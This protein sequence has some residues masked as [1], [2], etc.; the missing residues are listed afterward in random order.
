MMTAL[1]LPLLVW[2]VLVAVDAWRTRRDVDRLGM[3]VARGYVGE[4]V[5][6][7]AR[8]GW[9]LREGKR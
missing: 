5:Y 1:A 7:V 8:R 6:D 9:R 4:L 2:V 3:A